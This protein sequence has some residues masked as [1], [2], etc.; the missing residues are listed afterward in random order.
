GIGTSQ[1]HAHHLGLCRTGTHG[2]L[3]GPKWSGVHA[4]A[5][6]PSRRWFAIDNHHALRAGQEERVARSM[7]QELDLGIDLTEVRFKAQG[8]A[9]ISLFNRCF[10]GSGSPSFRGSWPRQ[11]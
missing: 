1:L 4:T 8:E 2:L 3:S 10:V 11:L 7:H 6:F 5:V 9:A